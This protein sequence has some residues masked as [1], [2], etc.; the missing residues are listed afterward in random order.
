MNSMLARRRQSSTMR[1]SHT[2]YGL[3]CSIR[4]GQKLSM[5]SMPEWIC[6]I[7]Y[8]LE[9]QI[10]LISSCVAFRSWGI[11]IVAHI[12]HENGEVGMVEVN[13]DVAHTNHSCVGFEHNHA[14]AYAF[15]INNIRCQHASWEWRYPP[16]FKFSKVKHL[17]QNSFIL[18]QLLPRSVAT[19]HF[20]AAVAASADYKQKN[21][22]RTI[23]LYVI[24][25][26]SGERRRSH[27]AEI[28]IGSENNRFYNTY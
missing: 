18:S 10:F 6:W 28:K 12:R 11:Y 26:R 19:I 15:V 27:L 24:H 17:P 13:C 2:A 14:Y 5:F 4:A 1:S 16:V 25:V 3:D 23:Y 7:N 8:L 22:R 9:S 21:E 20:F